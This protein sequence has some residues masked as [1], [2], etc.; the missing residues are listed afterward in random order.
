MKNYEFWISEFSVR[1]NSLPFLLSECAIDIE[2][3]MLGKSQEDDSV[4]YLSKLLNESTKG[5]KPRIAL[6]NNCIAIFDAMN[7]LGIPREYWEGRTVGDIVLNVNLL[8]KDL[9]DFKTLPR[10]GQETLRNFCGNLNRAIGMHQ[11]EYLGYGLQTS[12][13]AA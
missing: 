7:S 5:E 9:R 3:Y 1:N 6:P 13:L 8:A 10:E 11:L 4:K 2:N 12:C